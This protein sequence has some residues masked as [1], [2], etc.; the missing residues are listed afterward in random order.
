MEVEVENILKS[1]YHNYDDNA[2]KIRQF[3]KEDVNK[4]NLGVRNHSK[5]EEEGREDKDKGDLNQN[6]DD[7][8]KVYFYFSLSGC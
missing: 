2:N 6:N 5:K 4:N 3:F 8:D 7:D 1:S